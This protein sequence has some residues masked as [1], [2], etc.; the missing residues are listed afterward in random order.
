M[1]PL[2]V[3]S[4]EKYPE[5]IKDGRLAQVLKI[6]LFSALFLEIAWYYVVHGIKETGQAAQGRAGTSQDS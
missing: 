4:D 5:Y 3:L 1:C 6:P 2:Y